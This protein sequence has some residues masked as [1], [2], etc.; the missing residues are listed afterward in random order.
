MTDF[1]ISQKLSKYPE[2]IQGIAYNQGC[3]HYGY[4]DMS[5]KAVRERKAYIESF[6]INSDQIVLSQQEHSN[7]VTI[8]DYKDKGRGVTDKKMA[9]KNNDGLIT[10][11]DD[12]YLGVFTA[13]CI[14]VS[15]YDPIRKIVG[16]AH[17]GWRGTV[18]NIVEQV[19]ETF[20][21][22]GSQP[23]NIIAYLGPAISSCCYEVSRAKDD[24]VRQF[25]K[26]FGDKVVINRDNKIY[27][28][29][30]TAITTQLKQAGVSVG[31]IEKSEICT[32]CSSGYNLPSYHR[33][34]EKGEVGLMLSIIGR[35]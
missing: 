7:N 35:R 28:D 14:P 12:I 30:V 26:V 9:I 34:K 33:D 6:N 15:F 22:L 10:K 8:V 1:I 19:I 5:L 13:D 18:S 27:L 17:A 32:S 2:I 24:R 29:L 3:L 21:K 4:A 11:E 20:L 25:Q 23:E 31:N 16:I